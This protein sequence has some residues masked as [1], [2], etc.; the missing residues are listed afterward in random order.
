MSWFDVL[1]V[2]FIVAVFVA[3]IDAAK[4]FLVGFL[5]GFREESAKCSV[6]LDVAK[7]A[8]MRSHTIS[9]EIPLPD[10]PAKPVPVTDGI[11][12]PVIGSAELETHADGSVTGKVSMA[13]PPES[14]ESMRDS[15]GGLL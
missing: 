6:A 8:E 2:A 4:A 9:E 10:Y 5:R 1:A 15:G 12:G 7:D 3:A 13:K 14:Y 11:G